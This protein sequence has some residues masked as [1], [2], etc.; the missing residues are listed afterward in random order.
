MVWQSTYRWV[1]RDERDGSSSVRYPCLKECWVLSGR[2]ISL[3]PVNSSSS[4]PISH[5]AAAALPRSIL[6]MCSLLFFWVISSD[7]SFLPSP[8]TSFCALV[9]WLS[10]FSL[11]FETGSATNLFALSWL[12]CPGRAKS[13]WC[14][15]VHL[16]H[17]FVDAGVLGQRR[18]LALRQLRHPHF[19]LLRGLLGAYEGY[20]LLGHDGLGLNLPHQLV[21]TG[22][23]TFGQL[24]GFSF[25]CCG[26]NI[27]RVYQELSYLLKRLIGDRHLARTTRYLFYR[28]AWYLCYWGLS[29]ALSIDEAD[30]ACGGFVGGGC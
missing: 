19:P 6:S 28:F 4:H 5:E 18:D 14:I 23:N 24:G 3:R 29:E 11:R 21:I 25:G 7:V 10:S 16:P 2:L 30:Y 15:N 12:V 26:H 8:S 22:K 17:A 9:I 27:T 20:L 13:S 1:G